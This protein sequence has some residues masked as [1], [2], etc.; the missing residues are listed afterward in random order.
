MA[1]AATVGDDDYS[2]LNISLTFVPG[3]GDGKEL[4]ASVTTSSDDQVES[5]ENF[6]VDLALLTQTGTSFSL[7]N[8]ETAILLTDNE[9]LGHHANKIV[10][11]FISSLSCT[12][13]DTICDN[14]CRK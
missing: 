4:C 1:A 11:H 3:S 7:G 6:T 14:G 9:G 13:W 8:S 5:D 12:V 2:A 10:L